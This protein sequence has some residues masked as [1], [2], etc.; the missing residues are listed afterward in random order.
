MRTVE[1]IDGDVVIVGGSLAGVRTAEALRAH[2]HRGRLVVVNDE[3]V[4]PYDRPP[5]TK[6]YLAGKKSVEDMR[7]TNEA[8]LGRLGIELRSGHRAV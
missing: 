5:L 1:M 6:E 8:E 4:L 2:G 3:A 7:L